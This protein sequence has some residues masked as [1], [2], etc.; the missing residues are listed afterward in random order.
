MGRILISSKPITCEKHT[1]YREAKW[2]ISVLGEK[3]ENNR[4]IPEESGEKYYK[5]II[6]YPMVARLLTDAF[7]NP[8]DFSDHCVTKRKDANGN[9]TYRFNTMPIGSITDS[10]IQEMEIDG[11]TKKCIVIS[12]KLWSDR[13]PEYFQVL[14]K[15][16]E[17]G[18]VSSSWELD[19]SNYEFDE[20][21]T[22]ILRDFEFVGNCILGSKVRGAV[23]R[24][25]ML[26]YAS[27]ENQEE[28]EAELALAS[29]LSQDIKNTE[30]GDKMKEDEKTVEQASSEV[31]TET[32]NAEKTEQVEETKKEESSVTEDEK[33]EQKEEATKEE[34]VKEESAKAEETEKEQASLTSNDIERQLEDLCY[35]DYDKYGY[36]SYLFPEEHYALCRTYRMNALTFNKVNYSVTDDKV[37]IDS[38]E[39]VTL[40]VEVK[41]IN[42]VIAQK[43][44]TIV[45]LNTENL[46]LKKQVASLQKD[47]EELASIKKEQAEAELK[48]KQAE[49]ASYV[50]SSNM[51]SAEELE[52]EEVKLAIASVDY[53]A[54]KSMIADKVV[55]EKKEVAQKEKEIEVS[56]KLNLESAS[57][58]FGFDIKSFI[59]R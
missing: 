13:F 19:V 12:S 25:G 6:G 20:D 39:P 32:E 35:D 5:T 4:I 26:E 47:S 43:D 8:V 2:L 3:D 37:S 54:I 45:A 48:T 31:S 46:S 42:T 40:A 14:D 7:G 23:T 30:V 10:E 38:V 1:N 11:E 59:S 44:D 57:T 53:P 52:S 28:D 17:D 21:K 15:L 49:I 22:K 41:D 36:V 56:E 16:W 58:G 18:N 34:P 24:A 51:F 50:E 27:V 33:S 55:A 9:I 29:A